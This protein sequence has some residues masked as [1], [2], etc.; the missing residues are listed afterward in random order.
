MILK[1]PIDG[2]MFDQMNCPFEGIS[3]H[4]PTREAELSIFDAILMNH[5]VALAFKSFLAGIFSSADTISINT[6]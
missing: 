4:L 6:I 2:H 1:V 5:S 3:L